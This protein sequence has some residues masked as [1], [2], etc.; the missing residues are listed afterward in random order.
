MRPRYLLSIA[1]GGAHTPSAD[2]LAELTGLDV[3]HR[4]HPLVALAN[5]AALTPFPTKGGVVLGPVDIHFA[6]RIVATRCQ[7]AV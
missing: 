3:I 1:H 2:R 7:L 5:P 6:A 4:E